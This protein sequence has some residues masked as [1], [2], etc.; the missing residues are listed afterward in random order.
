MAPMGTPGRAGGHQWDGHLGHIQHLQPQH[1]A[2]GTSRHWAA[3]L[4]Q[5]AGLQ[6]GPQGAG[7]RGGSALWGLRPH[8]NPPGTWGHRGHGGAEPGA[9][10]HRGAQRCD[11]QGQ[12][13]A[14]SC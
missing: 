7:G 2:E 1:M 14:G 10:W 9:R 13:D 4:G 5:G 8:Q 6:E 11:E 3:P 12:V